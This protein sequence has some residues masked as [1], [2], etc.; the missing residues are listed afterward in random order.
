MDGRHAIAVLYIQDRETGTDDAMSEHWKLKQGE[1]RLRPWHDVG[2][3][4]S[5]SVIRSRKRHRRTLDGGAG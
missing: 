4:R 2:V 1:V 5:S 3:R